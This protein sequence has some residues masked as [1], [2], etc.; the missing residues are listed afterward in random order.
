MSQSAATSLQVQQLLE[1]LA[2]VMSF[3]DEQTAVHGAAERA[4]QALEAEVSAVMYGDQVAA[5]VGFPAGAVPAAELLAVADGKRDWLDVPGLERCHAFAASWNGSHPGHLIIARAG[6]DTFSPEERSLVRGMARVLELTLTMLRTLR[7]EQEMRERSEL[8][9]VENA[10]L[11]E[12]LR[13]QQRLLLHVS[14][15]QRGISRRDPLQQILEAVTTAAQDLLGDE[16]IGLWVRDPETPERAR[17]LASVGL[18]TTHLPAMPL[19][20]T[21]AVGEAMRGND[22][23]VAAGYEYVGPAIREL[24]GGRLCVSMAAPVHESGAIVGG[25]LVASYDPERF[26]SPHDKQTL[27]AFAQNVSLAL[28]DAHTLDRVNRAVHDNLTGLANRGLFLQRLTEQIREGLPAA[29]LFID[30]DRFKPIND[31]L[32][33][34][35]G[36]QILVITAVRIQSQLRSADLAGRFGGDEFAVMLRGVAELDTGITIARRLV[37]EI[38]RPVDLAGRTVSVD[39][40]IGIALSVDASNAADLMQHADIAMYRAKRN[41]RGRYEV[42]TKDLMH[43]YTNDS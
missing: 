18:P 3:S 2:V 35:A 14:D 37:H 13:E 16:I 42:F 23:V 36:D 22:V 11:A 8:Q 27:R 34:A 10:M 29:L 28:T 26:Y 1:L 39:A 40:S 31:A 20:E 33:H 7:A 4:A 6:D 25:L 17:L 24:T 12:S 5:A 9:A 21:G 30:L 19:T 15:I 41:G 43:A 38:G 32:G